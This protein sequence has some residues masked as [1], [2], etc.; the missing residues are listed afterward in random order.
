MIVDLV[1]ALNVLM[2]DLPGDQFA[3]P[4]LTELISL[5]LSTC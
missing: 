4:I 1:I 3:Y 5:S 2:L